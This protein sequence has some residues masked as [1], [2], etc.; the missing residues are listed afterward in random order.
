MPGPG[1][2][3]A[4]RQA[5]YLAFTI[6]ISLANQRAFLPEVLMA[7][8]AALWGRV[9][10]V[11]LVLSTLLGWELCRFFPVSGSLG[12]ARL[13]FERLHVASSHRAAPSSHAVHLAETSSFKEG[14]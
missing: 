13:W 5:H 7:R 14:C 6:R 9:G 3:G 4:V 2:T 10:W 8:A 1:L 12:C 11:R